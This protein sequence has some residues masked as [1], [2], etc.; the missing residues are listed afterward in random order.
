M[1]LTCRGMVTMGC[2]RTWS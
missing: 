2:V 1:Y